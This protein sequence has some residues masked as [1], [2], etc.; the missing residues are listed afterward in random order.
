[1]L[2]RWDGFRNLMLGDSN[3]EPHSQVGRALGSFFEVY[4]V[5]CGG[6][7]AFLHRVLLIND[8]CHSPQPRKRQYRLRSAE[9]RVPCTQ[10]MLYFCRLIENRYEGFVGDFAEFALPL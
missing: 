3:G 6:L 7:P 9:R 10:R 4:S 1:M 5:H 8:D 2:C